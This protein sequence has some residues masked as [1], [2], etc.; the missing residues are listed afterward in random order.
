M[1]ATTSRHF[2]MNDF[3]KKPRQDDMSAPL[4]SA[5]DTDRTR[6]ILARCGF[7][8]IDTF[9]AAFRALYRCAR[10]LSP[11]TITF[12][13][14]IAAMLAIAMELHADDD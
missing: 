10:R 13:L 9:L 8:A 12:I 1:P 3:A 7:G 2:S 5:D 4:S 14:M 11:L 6:V